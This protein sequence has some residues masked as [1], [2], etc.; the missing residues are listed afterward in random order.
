MP[1]MH[2]KFYFAEIASALDYLHNT[3]KIVYRDLKPENIL[4]NMNGHV[5][6][7]DMGFAVPLTGA[8]ADEGKFKTMQTEMLEHTLIDANGLL[9]HD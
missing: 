9:V 1:Q 7:C 4:I 3:L 6:L 5:K 2:A 8:S